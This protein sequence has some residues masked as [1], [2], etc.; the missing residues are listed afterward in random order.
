[1]IAVEH[2]LLSIFVVLQQSLHHSD[3]IALRNVSTKFKSIWRFICQRSL[4]DL[5]ENCTMDPLLVH[6]GKLV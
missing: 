2:I 4:H 5:H 6:Y 1:M 3:L